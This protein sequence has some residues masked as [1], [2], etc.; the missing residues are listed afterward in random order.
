MANKP[1]SDEDIRRLLACRGSAE[2]M[3][4]EFP[5]RSIGTLKASL[6]NYRRSRP[7]LAPPAQEEPEPR[8]PFEEHAVPRAQYDKVLR[9]L[10]EVKHKRADYIHAVVTAATEAIENITIAAVPRPAKDRRRGTEEVAVALLSDLQTGKITPDYNTEVCRERVIRYAH[11]IVELAQKQRADHPVRKCVVAMLGD[12]VE[13]V[14]IFP[15]QQWLI[16]STLY[17]QIFTSTPTILVDFLRILLADFEEVEVWAVQ[18]NHGRIG[19]RGVFGPEDNADRFVY[20]LVK[21]MMKDEP[22]LKFIMSD[23]KGER[24]WYLVG[25][26]GAWSALLIHGDQ[27]KPTL[28]F[29]YYG[30]GK[31]VG[32]WASGGIPETFRDVLLGHWHQNAIIPL[33]KR[34]AYVNGST[35]SHNTY[36]SEFL[37]AQSDPSQRLM[38]VHPVKG[39]VT[40]NFEVYLL[41]GE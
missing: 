24:A 30:L 25:E 1:W 33:N 16:D 17:E 11:K 15:G 38:F 31:K 22:R 35:E 40:M 23:P 13:G 6:H 28:G 27:I 39:Y 4:A 19:R 12:M 41:D 26:I 9:Q 20:K 5:G 37:A 21:L 2:R 10:H 3:T 36:A 8:A 14:D 18:G 7:D 29:P 32:G 34:K